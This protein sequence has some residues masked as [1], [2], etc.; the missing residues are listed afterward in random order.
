MS[1][2]GSR[3]VSPDPDEAEKPT[4][5]NDAEALPDDAAR[6]R[7]YI[8]ALAACGGH[9]KLVSKGENKRVQKAAEVKEMAREK[10]L[11]ERRRERQKKKNKQTVVDIMMLL[12][13]N[14][15]SDIRQEFMEAEDGLTL[16]SFVRVMLKYLSKDESINTQDLVAS[17]CELFA[18][19][20]V[21]GDATME[22]D[23]F[24]GYIH[25]QGMAAGDDPASMTVSVMKYNPKCVWEDRVLPKKSEN[26]VYYARTDWIGINEHNS[27]KLFVY[28][29]VQRRMV[30]TLQHK[31][32]VLA[33]EF[34]EVRGKKL[35]VVSTCDYGI[36]I[37]D[38][39]SVWEASGFAELQPPLTAQESQT[40][41]FWDESSSTLYSGGVNGTVNTWDLFLHD[42]KASAP[43]LLGHKSTVRVITDIPSLNGMLTASLD[44]TMI[45]WDKM[46]GKKRKTYRGHRNGILAVAFSADLKIIVSAGITDELMVWNSFVEKKLSDLVGHKAPMLGLHVVGGV[47]DG[48]FQLLSSD[49]SGIFKVWDLR[50][51]ECIQTFS[52]DPQICTAGIRAYVNLA[53]KNVVIAVSPRRFEEFE[54]SYSNTPELTDDQEVVC[55]FYN[56][57]LDSFVT[58]A[59][60]HLRVWE[61]STGALQ[62]T[63]TIGTPIVCMCFDD[64]QRKF[65]IGDANGDVNCY[66]YLNGVL[67]KEFE[68][69]SAEVSQITYCDED[70]CLL[71]TSWDRSL[72]IHDDMDNDEGV[73]LRTMKGHSKD[74]TCMANSF[75]LKLVATSGADGHILVWHYGLGLL[76][77]ICKGHSQD[78]TQLA[79][80]DPHPMLLSSDILGNIA[81]WG[82]PPAPVGVR[83]TCLCR[84]KNIL[85]D[86]APHVYSVVLAACTFP[87]LAVFATG[88]EAGDIKIRSINKIVNMFEVPEVP[89]PK[90]PT[91]QE[92]RLRR[93][94]VTTIPA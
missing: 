35:I 37:W 18:Q 89:P 84:V 38:T 85:L 49:K 7:H 25:E 8:A 28:D 3:P 24:Y 74:I 81:I 29:I 10:N 46:T 31:A 83:F 1:F 87:D 66:N 30:H 32:A 57:T 9:Q 94:G 65:F 11:V 12:D 90:I 78:V 88:D 26:V 63:F 93:R 82:V 59:G 34:I 17:L 33:S 60:G 77:G 51:L 2:D 70:K 41:L 16:N 21:N 68:A 56:E 40:S 19:V 13:T 42:A 48:A 55:A 92:L 20:D 61:S 23:E 69:H 76:E 64:R 22:W 72:C 14:H 91:V 27:A 47:G 50:S 73:L 4:A 54:F 80:L 67:M 39:Q 53:H 36:T 6:I 86:E 79:F 75:A 44:G 58:A 71:T 43:K 62:K 5:H 15:L 45:L 52:C